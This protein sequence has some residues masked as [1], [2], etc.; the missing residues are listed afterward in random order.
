[1]SKYL[2]RDLDEKGFGHRA[3]FESKIK[4]AFESPRGPP[5]A[6]QQYLPVQNSLYCSGPIC[7]HTLNAISVSSS[8]NKYIYLFK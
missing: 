4:A 6:A 5:M 3:Q 2:I 8:R 1:M 7:G